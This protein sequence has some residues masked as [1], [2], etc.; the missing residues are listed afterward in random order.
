[1]NYEQIERE[2]PCLVQGI[3]EG[4][5]KEVTSKQRPLNCLSHCL[6]TRTTQA[7]CCGVLIYFDDVILLTVSRQ[8]P[9]QEHIFD[10]LQ[11]SKGD[12]NGR[13][14]ITGD[15]K[16]EHHFIW[17]WTRGEVNATFFHPERKILEHRKQITWLSMS[18]DEVCHG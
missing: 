1:M 10:N 3:K 18:R 4:F 14:F 17:G 13:N 6:P 8:E 5:L 9:Q 12:F 7:S 16:F 11:K 2:V 15:Q